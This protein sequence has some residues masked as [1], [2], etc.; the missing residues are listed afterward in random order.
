MIQLLILDIRNRVF[1]AARLK[2]GGYVSRQGGGGYSDYLCNC[3][4]VF[5]DKFSARWILTFLGFGA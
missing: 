4:V 1:L 5:S 3:Y 2:A